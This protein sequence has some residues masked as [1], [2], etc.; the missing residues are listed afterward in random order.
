MG[1]CILSD[2]T[3]SALSLSQLLKYQQPRLKFQERD[4]WMDFCLGWL[5][6]PGKITHTQR[7]QSAFQ[8][9]IPE[10]EKPSNENFQNEKQTKTNKQRREFQ[11]NRYSA[12]SKRGC[13]HCHHH[14]HAK[15]NKKISEMVDEIDQKKQVKCQTWKQQKR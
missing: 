5:T 2:G 3:L 9:L 15:N 6:D 7:L 1:I 11:E 14:C 4:W 8:C 10:Y 12:R 13:H